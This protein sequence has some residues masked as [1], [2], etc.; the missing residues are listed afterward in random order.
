MRIRSRRSYLDLT[1]GVFR[2]GYQVRLWGG[3][4]KFGTESRVSLDLAYIDR[5]SLCTWLTVSGKG[6]RTTY[7]LRSGQPSI[8]EQLPW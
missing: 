1:V 4:L 3:E 5:V 7:H 6:E 8:A 2:R